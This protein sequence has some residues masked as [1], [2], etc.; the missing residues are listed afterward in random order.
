L[1][2]LIALTI[3]S[4]SQLKA[5]VVKRIGGDSV[6]VL[7]IKQGIAINTLIDSLEKQVSK[8]DDSIS[9]LNKTVVTYADSIRLIDKSFVFQKEE[10][11]MKNK[12]NQDTLNDYKTRYYKNIAIY[13]QFEKDVKFEQKLHRFNSVLFTLLVIFLYSQIK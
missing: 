7:T 13:N 11:V 12:I 2:L 5:Q 1:T 9:V 8:K 4:H 6:V 3:V 10:L